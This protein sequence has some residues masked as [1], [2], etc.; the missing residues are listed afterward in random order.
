MADIKLETNKL[1]RTFKTQEEAIEY[2]E[3]HIPEEKRLLYMGFFLGMN[4]VANQVNT[5]F[6]LKYKD[7]K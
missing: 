2:M 7:K 3:M 1:F 6:D 5:T 4:F